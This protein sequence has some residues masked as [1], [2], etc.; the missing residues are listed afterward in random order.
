MLRVLLMQQVK[1][2]T[3]T[4]GGLRR[5]ALRAVQMTPLALILTIKLTWTGR[6]ANGH[7]DWKMEAF[8]NS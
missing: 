4:E 8:F 3:G 2:A 6:A 7:D 5:S 1:D